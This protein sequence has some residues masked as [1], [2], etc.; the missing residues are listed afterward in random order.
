[1]DEIC[2][3]RECLKEINPEDHPGI[4]I[5]TPYVYEEEMGECHQCEIDYT[6]HGKR[7]TPNW[8]PRPVI[9]SHLDKSR[10]QPQLIK[11]RLVVPNLTSISEEPKE[12]PIPKRNPVGKPVKL[13]LFD[14]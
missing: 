4:W 3:G 11:R 13:S 6:L 1:M 12:E 2:R 5:G 10:P 7:L 8:Q 14:L 9:R